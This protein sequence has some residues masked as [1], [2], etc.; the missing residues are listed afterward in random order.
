M[1]WQCLL[2]PWSTEGEQ[3]K[4]EEEFPFSYGSCTHTVLLWLPNVE[5][6]I[7][8]DFAYLLF[9]LFLLYPLLCLCTVIS[10]LPCVSSDNELKFR[11]GVLQFGS[12]SFITWNPSTS[13]FHKKK[14]Q[15][16]K[17]RQQQHQKQKHLNEGWSSQLY[18]QLLQLGKQSLKK[19]PAC[20]GFEPLTSTI[21]VQRST[22]K[23]A[24][25]SQRSRER[26][27]YKLE[28]FFFRLSFRNCKGCV[29]TA[30]IILHLIRLS[31]V[32]IIWFSYIQ[33]FIKK[34][35]MHFIISANI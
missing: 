1:L 9:F 19:I 20:T 2:F 6:I 24:P 5:W 26:I 11:C 29:I 27:P 7:V 23:T 17:T 35:P 14:K 10:L 16:N 8:I 13:R 28:F 18:T 32:H 30:M 34:T 21:P 33:K 3:A 15:Q 31:V 22:N 4:T 25:V 12:L